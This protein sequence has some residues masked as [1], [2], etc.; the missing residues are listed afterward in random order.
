MLRLTCLRV[1]AYGAS[2]RPS[3][4]C[5]AVCSLFASLCSLLKRLAVA[6]GKDDRELLVDLWQGGGDASS[7]SS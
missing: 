2:A 4:A 6:R 1:H 7:L 5:R 3:P